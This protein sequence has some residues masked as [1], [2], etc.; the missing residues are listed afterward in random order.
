MDAKYEGRIEMGGSEL[1]GEMPSLAS[2]YP[3][4]WE[5]ETVIQVPWEEGRASCL[6]WAS[7]RFNHDNL[8]KRSSVMMGNGVQEQ[9]SLRP[10]AP[11]VRHQEATNRW[12]LTKRA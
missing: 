2:N 5:K 3:S 10:P 12:K 7:E 6:L 9:P 1:R 4:N 11:K 8:I